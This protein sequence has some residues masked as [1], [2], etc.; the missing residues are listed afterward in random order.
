[1]N[2]VMIVDDEKNKREHIKRILNADGYCFVEAG[3][4]RE[5]LHLISQDKDIDVIIL[6]LVMPIM[7][8]YEALARIKHNPET[9][10]IPTVMICSDAS[11]LDMKKCVMMGVDD[12]FIKTALSDKENLELA[13]KIRNLLKLKRTQELLKELTSRLNWLDHWNVSKEIKNDLDMINEFKKPLSFLV[14]ELLVALHEVEQS[15]PLY[16][17][18]KLICKHAMKLSN[19]LIAEEKSTKY[20]DTVTY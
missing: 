19:V 1:M 13:I 12:C 6:D 2:K 11:F 17:R 16:N 4:G 9:C 8:G 7:H 5:A 10:H 15:M 14:A 3:N 20:E 18:L